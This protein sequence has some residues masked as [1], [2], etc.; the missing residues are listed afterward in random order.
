LVVVVLMPGAMAICWATHSAAS[1]AVAVLVF[2]DAYRDTGLRLVAPLANRLQLVAAA[3]DLLEQRLQDQE[4]PL[5]LLARDDE[6]D[7]TFAATNAH[8]GIV[9]G[10][11]ATGSF[12]R[13]GDEAMRAD[14]TLGNR[15][16][17]RRHSLILTLAP[18]AGK[19]PPVPVLVS[20]CQ[21]RVPGIGVKQEA[22]PTD[23]VAEWLDHDH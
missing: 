7:D 18:L 15:D 8:A 5:Q 13:C 6:V 2:T 14:E 16:G 20:V 10:L 4:R 9:A 11:H 17:G 23:S 12:A 1:P 21:R 22:L 19:R 3:F